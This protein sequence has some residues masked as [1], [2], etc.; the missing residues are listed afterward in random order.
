MEARWSDGREVSLSGKQRTVLA[1]LLLHVNTRVSRQ[2]L[3]EALWETPPASAVPNLQGYVAQLRRA[4]PPTTR[5]LTRG[6]GYL[7]EAGPEEVDLLAF[8]QALHLAQADHETGD[9][10]GAVQR[11]EKALSLWR[12]TLA[13]GTELAGPALA[14]AVQVEERRTAVRLKWAEAKLS[15]GR[16]AD[17]IEAL[18]AF[19]AEHPLSEPAWHV[20]MLALAQTG[21]RDAALDA[22]RHARTALVDQLGIE[23]GRLLQ[24]LQADILA[25]SVTGRSAGT[26]QRTC[27]LPSDIADF[28]GRADELGHV[29]TALTSAADRAAPAVVVLTGPPG[30]GKSTLAVHAAHRLRDAFS[31]GQ[32]YLS[33][34]SGVTAREPAALL[35]E[36]LRSLQ[37]PGPDIP[38]SVEGRAALYRSLLADRAVLVVLDDAEHESQV[39]CLLPG[40]PHSAVLVTSR[41]PLATLAGAARVPLDVPSEATGRSLLE[42]IAG[43]GRVRADPDA[44]RAIVLAC[45]RLPLAI[46]VAGARLATRPAWPLRELATRLAD[47]RPLDELALGELDIRKTFAVSYRLLPE[48]PRRVFRLIGL[49]GIDSVTEW[50]VA[51]LLGGSV[52]EVDAALEALVAAGLLSAGE[53]DQSGQ[54]RYR[55]HDLLRTF[56]YERAQAEDSPERR[57][58][59]MRRLVEESLARIRVAGLEYSPPLVPVMTPAGSAGRPRDGAAWLA[60]ERETLMTAARAAAPESAAE[61]AL[62][63]TPFLVMNG[64]QT[65]AIRLLR[66]AAQRAPD[67][68]TTVLA[69]LAL[70]D[71]ELDRGN[72][73]TARDMFRSVFDRFDQKDDSH[74]AAYALTGMVACDLMD[75]EPEQRT[76]AG[77]REAVSRFRSADGIVDLLDDLMAVC[78]AQPL[79][80]QEVIRIFRQVLLLAG[81]Q[82]FSES[83]MGFLRSLITAIVC[84]RKD[85]LQG[86]VDRYE[87]SLRIIRDLG[88]GPGE[89]YVL[90]RLSQVYRG[91]GRHADAV[92]ALHRL[93]LMSAKVSDTYSEALSAYFLGEISLEHGERQAAADY[94]RRCHDLMDEHGHSTWSARALQMIDVVRTEAGG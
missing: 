27:Q 61:F 20:L 14:R 62:R 94:F 11:Y 70:A 42:R 71:I 29:T 2:R 78:G 75:K 30:V 34:K 43:E 45:G 51:T 18:R 9:V 92:T 84:F 46:R 52:R 65:D 49:A 19:V 58:M 25:D 47:G 83:V 79:D 16:P 36:A 59:A 24:R 6:T 31:D 13:E 57:D 72:L 15:L 35:A 53:V 28:V 60:A 87:E 40:T 21:Q 55:L 1:S 76:P 88:W 50:I 26:W 80:H 69:H 56:A 85:D 39:Q 44:A 91:V 7:L 5:L 41:G 32:L 67:Q 81:E 3:V 93:S 77:I 66:D 22:Y 37:R 8:E 63:L 33:L 90:R 64:L 86:A 73:R 74:A 48:L 89:R 38:D 82:P 4:L 12:G 23:P 10:Q 17:V 54:S 68:D